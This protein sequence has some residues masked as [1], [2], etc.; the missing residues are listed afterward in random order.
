MITFLIVIFIWKMN[1]VNT[2][3]A[4]LEGIAVATVVTNLIGS[5][6]KMINS[7]LKVCIIYIVIAGIIVFS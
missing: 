3:T 7:A 6:E 4:T 5:G 2:F 1:I